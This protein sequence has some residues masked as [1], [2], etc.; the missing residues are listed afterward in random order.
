MEVP[1]PVMRLFC[2]PSGRWGWCLAYGPTDGEAR[3][4]ISSTLLWETPEEAERDAVLAAD[5]FRAWVANTS[6][7]SGADIHVF[8][9]G[10]NAGPRREGPDA[11]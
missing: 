5:S 2:H 10:P 8:I 1:P 7:M 4:A 11:R 6:D 3:P 9:T